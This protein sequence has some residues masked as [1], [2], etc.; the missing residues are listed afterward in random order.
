V[1]GFVKKLRGELVSNLTTVGNYFEKVI[2]NENNLAQ[3]VLSTMKDKP[4]NGDFYKEHFYTFY[5]LM[6]VE[7]K[8]LKEELAELLKIKYK[9]SVGGKYRDQIRYMFKEITHVE[10]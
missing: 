10:L 8:A 5:L 1:K 6:N 7:K 3:K 4:V 2:C 9:E